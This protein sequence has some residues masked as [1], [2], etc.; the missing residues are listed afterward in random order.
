MQM[1]FL[2]GTWIVQSLGQKLREGAS[3]FSKTEV[4][5]Y[6]HFIFSFNKEGGVNGLYAPHFYEPTFRFD[7][8]PH[9]PV[10]LH[11]KPQNASAQTSM[12][13]VISSTIQR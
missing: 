2:D 8:C 11:L 13:H 1:L 5:L 6:V 9:G 12:S 10:I 7:S 4:E 3:F